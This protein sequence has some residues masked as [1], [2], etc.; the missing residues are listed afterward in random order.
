MLH[1]PPH[2]LRYVPCCVTQQGTYLKRGGVYTAPPYLKRGGGV[3]H[4]RGHISRDNTAP[5]ERGGGVSPA[6]YISQ[7]RGGCYQQGTY[8][9]RWVPCC[10]TA[11]DISLEICPQQGTYLK[12]G[13]DVTHISQERG[14]LHNR[15]H[16]KRGEDVTSRG[17]SQEEGCYTT[18][19]ILRYVPCCVHIQ[20]GGGV[21]HPSLEIGCPLLCNILCPPLLR[22]VS[23]GHAV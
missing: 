9:L 20:E 4:S 7:E 6:V 19:D 5:L 22:Y 16:I 15:G 12:R 11:G 10:V 8:L 17:L 21:L 23:R 18:G 1:S 2:I 3:L 14:V 13:E